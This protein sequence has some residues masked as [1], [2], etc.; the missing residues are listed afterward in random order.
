[1]AEQDE[2]SRSDVFQEAPSTALKESPSAVPVE[3]TK[4]G[5][6]AL[7]TAPITAPLAPLTQSAL[8]KRLGCSDKAIEKHR[9]GGSKEQFATW[10]SARDPDNITWTWQGQGGRGQPLRFVPT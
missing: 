2:P 1:M 7:S 10:S 4:P 8:A 3:D 6:E 5:G 9:K